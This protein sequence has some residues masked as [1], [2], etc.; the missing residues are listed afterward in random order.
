[1]EKNPFESRR[2]TSAANRASLQRQ[3]KF[4]KVNEF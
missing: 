4:K 3:F 2:S 1:M